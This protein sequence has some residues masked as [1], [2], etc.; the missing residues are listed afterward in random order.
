MGIYQHYYV[1]VRRFD[2]SV[3]STEEKDLI[4]VVDTIPAGLV[5]ICM[6]ENPPES[7]SL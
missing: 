4:S 7:T 3:R 6:D 2:S 5:V 1:V